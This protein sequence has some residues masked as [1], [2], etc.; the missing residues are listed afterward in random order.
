MAWEAEL[1]RAGTEWVGAG[2]APLVGY[3]IDLLELGWDLVDRVPMRSWSILGAACL[4]ARFGSADW[5]S[6][7]GPL[8]CGRGSVWR[9]WPLACARGSVLLVPAGYWPLGVTGQ[10]FRAV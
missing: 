7:A 8:P 6:A 1:W 9:I 2:A 4:R 5:G 10:R 3:A